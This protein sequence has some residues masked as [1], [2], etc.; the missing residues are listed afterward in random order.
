MTDNP[1]FLAAGSSEKAFS[2]PANSDGRR[3]D[4]IQI[5]TV[6]ESMRD[7]GFD[8]T[9]A[10]GEPID[11]SIEADA[12]LIRVQTAYGEGKRA[13]N[14]IAF[15]DNGTGVK[16]DIMAHTLSMGFSSRY[17]ERGGLG[18]FGVG[19]KL[20]GLSLGRRIDIYTK[21]RDSEDIWHAYVDLNEIK[22]GKQTQI[23]SRAVTAWPEDYSKL[24]ET[25]DG[26]PFE[27]GTLVV[28]GKIDRLTSGGH[29]GTALD[30]KMS[31]LRAFIART[32][33]YFLSK[34]IQIELDGKP[35]TLLDPLFLLDNPRIIKRY[36]PADVR[37][38]V[39]DEGEIEIA[40]NQSI[41]VTVTLAPPEFRHRSGDG[42]YTDS[43]GRDI[44]EFQ[45]ADSAGKISMVRNGREI[46]YDIVPRLLPAGVDKVD[47][48]I[49]IEVKFPAELDEFFQVRNVK[50]GAVPVSKLREEL[51]GWLER[52]V[53]QARREIREHWG[54]I[55]T[56]ERANTDSYAKVTD[57]VAHVE[58]TS[59]R[60]QAGRDLTDEE[61]SQIIDEI[62]GDLNVTGSEDQ[63]SIDSVRK[64]IDEKPITLVDA[65]WPGSDLFRIR[66]LNGRA[67]VEINHRH[68]LWRDVFD[69]LKKAADDGGA[70]ATEQELVALIR[71]A[72]VTVEVL[73][74][75]Y[76]K[77]EN[78]HLN[79]DD[80][81][82]Q[83]RTYWGT[84]A[85]AYLG[86]VIKKDQ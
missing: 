50:R 83:L 17:G 46:N 58:K 21:R 2:G 14:E 67:I 60:G 27:S 57:A 33:R 59:P 77:A 10:A 79:P 65:Q 32:Y 24:M 1:V 68:P 3:A 35:V 81:F 38:V 31:E 29:Y 70:G 25:P 84:F 41:Y 9:A 53:K 45:V 85:K 55:E 34:G 4:I 48:Y 71:K 40:N 44:R 82:E 15:A 37:G 61:T 19:M 22:D 18:R 69:P 51:R 52:P 20:A 76:A 80:E 47:R 16:P 39:I 62:L 78:L 75:A 36:K 63:G 64:R 11:N 23:E 74:L 26:R 7:S 86:E 12:S 72:S 66:H 43:L 28:F 30:E 49:G 8:L 54:E 6:L 42:G 5:D 13:I 73:V 56:K